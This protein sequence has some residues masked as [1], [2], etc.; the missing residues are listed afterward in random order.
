MS[1][2]VNNNGV[3]LHE[4]LAKRICSDFLNNKPLINKDEVVFELKKLLGQYA[5]TDI[6]FLNLRNLVKC[7][8]ILKKI[9]YQKEYTESKIS[10]LFDYRGTPFRKTMEKNFTAVFNKV[11][12]HNSIM[13][14]FDTICKNLTKGSNLFEFKTEKLQ[15]GGHSYCVKK[16]KKDAYV[17]FYPSMYEGEIY[18]RRFF[19]LEYDLLALP[20]SIKACRRLVKKHNYKYKIPYFNGFFLNEVE[21]AISLIEEFNNKNN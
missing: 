7:L 15:T 8:C 13:K 14:S 12:V 11:I 20:G 4:D 5:I 18:L 16:N 9:D 6:D 17:I 1:D 10:E 3:E 19:S 2:S 21:M